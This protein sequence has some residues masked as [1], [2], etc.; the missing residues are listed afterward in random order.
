VLNVELDNPSAV[1]PLLTVKLQATVG[2]AKI[3][4]PA[5]EV[6]EPVRYCRCYGCMAARFAE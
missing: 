4:T 5:V 2:A 6:R 3:H 1:K